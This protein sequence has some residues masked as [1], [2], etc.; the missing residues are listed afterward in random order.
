MYLQGL[1]SIT[2]SGFRSIKRVEYDARLGITG[3]IGPNGA[4][5]TNLLDA[6]DFC[7]CLI[8]TSPLQA[9]ARHGGTASVF[10]SQTRSRRD[11]NFCI[12][13]IT[14]TPF[15][16]EADQSEKSP[17]R[18]ILWRY[19]FTIALD[20]NYQ[21]KVTNQDF[22]AHNCSTPDPSETAS[23]GNP[24]D[25][26]PHLHV[27]ETSEG[28][29]E[30]LSSQ[31][32]HLGPTI[33]SHPRDQS[34]TASRFTDAAAAILGSGNWSH[35]TLIARLEPIMFLCSHLRRASFAN[36]KFNINPEIIRLGDE[37]GQEPVISGNG[38]GL[39]STIFA[40]QQSRYPGLK[41]HASARIVEEIQ[42][43]LTLAVD[44]I[45]HVQ[46]RPNTS[47]GRIELYFQCRHAENSASF[48]IPAK[49]VS[50]GTLKW[51]CLMTAIRTSGSLIIDEPENYLHPWMQMELIEQIRGRVDS[52]RLLSAL[53]S[54]HSETILDSLLPSEILVVKNSGGSTRVARPKNAQSISKAIKDSGFGLG[55]FYRSGAIDL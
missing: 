23:G 14:H 43:L 47:S 36:H 39:A 28:K 35:D 33:G 51:L 41:K 10:R 55:Y 22:R 3:L 8:G 11:C 24:L 15:Y 13:C 26:A 49:S 44:Y 34:L 54:T 48:E 7:F 30:I 42:E 38:G 53:I 1:T 27:S 29:F 25:S 19:S 46:A 50:D 17:L 45:S 12:E 5:K 52:R 40:L 4:G 31:V 32:F 18:T 21:I 37:F 20:P 9:I 2:I 6:I 16:S